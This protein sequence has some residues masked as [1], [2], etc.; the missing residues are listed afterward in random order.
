MLYFFFFS[1]KAFLFVKFPLYL[2]LSYSYTLSQL[3]KFPPCPGSSNQIRY[4][5]FHLLE[6]LSPRIFWPVQSG[7][8][9]FWACCLT[10]SWESPY[11]CILNI[12]FTSYFV[13]SLPVF[14]FFSSFQL[15]IFFRNFLIKDV[16]EAKYCKLRHYFPILKF[17]W[18]FDWFWILIGYYFPSEFWS[19]HWVGSL[20]LHQPPLFTVPSLS[21]SSL[22]FSIL[23]SRDVLFF[24]L[25]RKSS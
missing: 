9:D 3:C 6:E 2:S 20:E 1:G 21:L 16:R 18:A 5:Q 11:N 7:F 10:A 17:N 13:D 22:L 25:W 24:S 15:N 8:V 19:K 4:C 23:Q 12:T 14:F